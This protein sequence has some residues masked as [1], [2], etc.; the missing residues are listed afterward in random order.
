MTDDPIRELLQEAD[1]LAGP[2]PTGPEDLAARVRLSARRRRMAAAT[3][4]VA[5]LVAAALVVGGML[6]RE[7]PEQKPDIAEV[8]EGQPTTPD[9]EKLQAEIDRLQREIDLRRAIVNHLVLRERLRDAQARLDRLVSGPSVAERLRREEDRVA[10]D[11]AR[12]AHRLEQ[13]LG[14]TDL[15]VEAYGHVVR[16][17][18][19]TIWARVAQERVRTLK[20]TQGGKL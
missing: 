13:L 10:F 5:L 16:L 15:A 6:L 17:F 3:S 18:P 4:L 1:R 14:R 7:A 20:S 12:R 2:A 8:A 9:A 19:T 11:V